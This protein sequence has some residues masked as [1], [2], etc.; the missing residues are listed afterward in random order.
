MPSAYSSK[1]GP[2]MK[3]NF[4]Q[5]L[6]VSVV[7]LGLVWLFVMYAHLTLPNVDALKTKNPVSTAFMELYRGPS[8]LQYAWVPYSKIAPSLKQAVVIAEDSAF[9]EHSGFDW[10]AIREAFAKDWRKKE[11]ARGGSTITQQLAKNLYLSPSK[12]PLRK[13]KEILITVQ[14]EQRLSKQR[15]LEIY[16]NVVEWGEGIYGAESAAEYYFHTKAGN[17]SPAQSA[18]LAAIL[19]NPKYY[20]NHRDRALLESKVELILYRMGY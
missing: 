7:S 10:Q 12:N 8:S 5:I 17:L 6:A 20:Q 1:N 9:F 4:K 15:I 18:W 11:L 13:L 14:L 19:P 16:L 2:N 3:K